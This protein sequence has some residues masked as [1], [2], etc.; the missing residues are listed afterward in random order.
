MSNDTD[1]APGPDE[2][3]PGTVVTDPTKPATPVDPA[4]KTPEAKDGE[5]SVDGQVVTPDHTGVVH[6]EQN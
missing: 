6:D 4:L 5:E 2:V 3:I 1:G